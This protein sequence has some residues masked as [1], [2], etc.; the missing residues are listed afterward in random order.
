VA[1]NF[2]HLYPALWE[3][4]PGLLQLVQEDQSIDERIDGFTKGFLKDCPGIESRDPVF[5]EEEVAQLKKSLHQLHNIWGKDAEA[6]QKGCMTTEAINQLFPQSPLSKL[7]SRKNLL[8]QLI[9]G[10]RMAAYWS[11]LLAKRQEGG[12]PSFFSPQSFLFSPL[13]L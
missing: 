12:L 9:F 13:S 6:L 8:S 4:H 1:E 11:R 7:L 5:N 3:Q 2:L 10:K